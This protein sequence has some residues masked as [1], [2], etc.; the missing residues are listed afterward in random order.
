M[1]DVSIA[2]AQRPPVLLDLQSSIERAV[3]TINEAADH[4]AKLILFPEAFLP[5]YPTWIW[6][7]KPGGD[8][9]L[10]NTIHAKLRNNS[11][12]IA[13]GDL[14]EICEAAKRNN[15]VVAMGMNELDSEFSGS[16]IYNTVVIIDSEGEILNRHRKLMPTNPERMVWGFGDARGLNVVETAVGRI[17]CL[18]CWENYMPLARYSLY[19]QDIDIYLAP[20]WDCGDTWLAS[21]RHIAKEGGCWVL[22]TATAIE[23]KDVP[24]D[25][26]E[27]DR[28]FNEEEW[29]NP[30]GAVVIKPSGAIAD[31]PLNNQ[32]EI[33]YS[34]INVE[35]SRESRKSLDVAGHYHRP[36][37]FHLEVDRRAA[38]PVSFTDDE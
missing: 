32:K 13:N 29:I 26:P 20:T 35:A 31:G 17:G 37:V 7:L 10:S 2:I 27:R 18:I 9:G 1:M 24:Q 38:P 25:F 12:D 21:M 8:L 15:I 5:G 33:L 4:G 14:N 28:L 19:A 30:G 11:V 6:R 23:G 36:D 34:T 22:S 3:S 16:T